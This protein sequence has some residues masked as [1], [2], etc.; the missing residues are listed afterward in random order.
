MG[1]PIEIATCMPNQDPIPVNHPIP[2][3]FQRLAQALRLLLRRRPRSIADLPPGSV[4]QGVDP[5]LP[6]VRRG[7]LEGVDLDSLAN[8]LSRRR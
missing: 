3:L 2:G 4:R 5:S 1:Y 6:P 8:D 7:D